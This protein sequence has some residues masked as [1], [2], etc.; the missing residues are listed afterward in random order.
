MLEYIFNAH[1]PGATFT[2]AIAIAIWLAVNNICDRFAKMCIVHTFIN[3]I[4][5]YS[6]RNISSLL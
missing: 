1:Y 4:L 2:I 6:I 3:A 5:K